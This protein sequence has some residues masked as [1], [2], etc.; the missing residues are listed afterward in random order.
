[1]MKT[2]TTSHNPTIGFAGASSVHTESADGSDVNP[3]LSAQLVT[4]IALSPL[5]WN[6]VSEQLGVAGYDNSMT[7]YLG[8]LLP[9]LQ[10]ALGKQPTV[11][12]T[13]SK[14]F[15]KLNLNQTNAYIQTFLEQTLRFDCIHLQ[16]DFTLFSGPYL[17]HQGIQ[18]FAGLLDDLAQQ[19]PQR[20]VFTTFH[21]S[22]LPQLQSPLKLLEQL[23][24]KTVVKQF[25]QGT[26]HWAVCHHVH[27][28]QQ[29]IASG[30]APEKVCLMPYVV[31][32][33]PFQQYPIQPQLNHEVRQ[34]LKLKPTDTVLG[35]FGFISPSKRFEDAIAALS[36]LPASYKLLI[37]GGT[38]ESPSA[39]HATKATHYE[40]QLVQLVYEAGLQ[41]RVLITGLFLNEAL[42][43]YLDCVDL[44]IAPYS[45]HFSGGLGASSLLLAANKPVIASN[46]PTFLDVQHQ[47]QCLALFE[48]EEVEDLV[49]TVKQLNDSPSQ[50]AFLVQA[51][52]Q[53]VQEH[54]EQSVATHLVQ[55]YVTAK[56]TLQASDI[57]PTEYAPL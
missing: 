21:Q 26:V 35:V 50:Q 13:D 57:Q 32:Q 47:S 51:L 29:L 34:R 28:R 33:Q 4:A 16:H 56:A 17:P 10:Q 41:N 18:L 55:A 53:Y 44:F 6:P 20:P 1:M 22:P 38:H 46:C 31:S 24:W 8:Q 11:Y 5:Y 2:H 42:P 36:F 27:I 54:G 3:A 15:K 45:Q 12:K 43:T 49:N 7:T 30:I 14:T 23:A 37:I 39:H 40:A 9:A 52:N 25:Q 48:A 19:H